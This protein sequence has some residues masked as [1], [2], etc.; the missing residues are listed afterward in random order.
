MERSLEVEAE[1]E[2]E[3]EVEDESLQGEVGGRGGSAMSRQETHP[4]IA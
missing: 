4:A 3:V 2:V 1:V